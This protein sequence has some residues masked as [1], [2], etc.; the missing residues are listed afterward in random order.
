MKIDLKKAIVDSETG[1]KI[2][3]NMILESW[4]FFLSKKIRRITYLKVVLF[5][6]YWFRVI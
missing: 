3:N 5:L 2:V 6:V 1:E 4:W